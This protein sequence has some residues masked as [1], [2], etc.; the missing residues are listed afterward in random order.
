MSKKDAERLWDLMVEI[1]RVTTF[2]DPILGDVDEGCSPAQIHTVMWLG[3]DGPLTMS[4]LASRL[5]SKLPAC[6]GIVDRI[7]RTG[8]VERERDPS[9]RRVVRVVLTAAGAALY[10]ELKSRM[11]GRMGFVLGALDAEDRKNLIAILGRL[12][13]AHR[14]SESAS[15]ENDA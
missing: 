9:D 4:E 8:L 3:T 15:M 11:L 7:E 12:V 5:R 1:G 13:E 6:T 2:R 14:A 10:D